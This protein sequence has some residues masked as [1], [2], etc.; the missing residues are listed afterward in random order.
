VLAREN[1]ASVHAVAK[2]VLARA[3]SYYA[4]ARWGLRDLP[5]RAALAVAVAR[6]VYREIGRIV[7]RGGPP[8]LQTRASPSKPVMLW[9]VFRGLGMALFSRFE[10]LW[11][12]APR[13]PL[14][15]RI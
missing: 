10:R 11:R 2:R 15:S 13:P 6:G 4:S 3:D 1:A 8:A 9:L 14:W 12:P 7:D 5:T